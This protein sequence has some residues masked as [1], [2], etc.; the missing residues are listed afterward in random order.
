[1][2]TA[3]VPTR[4]EVSDVATAVYEG[5]DAVMLSA[6]SAAGQYPVEAVATMDRVAK[7]VESDTNYSSIILAQRAEPDATGADALAAAA[8]QIA[9]TLNVGVIACYTTSGSTVM[10]VARERPSAEVFA[11]CSHV[12]TARRLGIVWGV[13]S[14]TGPA[15][16]D[17]DRF[18]ALAGERIVDLGL[19]RTGDRLLAVAGVPLDTPGVT[20]ALQLAF[21]RSR[22]ER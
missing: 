18:I 9:E 16:P 13:T 6:E 2:I 17:I 7:A 19:G 15:C 8:R 14:I 5:A 12:P 4:A 1:M 10:R 3:P 11:L 20:N 21:V 22:D